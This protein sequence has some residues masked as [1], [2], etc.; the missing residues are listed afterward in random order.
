M[1][2]LARNSW[3]FQTRDKRKVKV[4]NVEFNSLAPDTAEEMIN[5]RQL[6]AIWTARAKQGSKAAKKSKA[7]LAELGRKLLQDG[8][9]AMNGVEVLGEGMEKSSR[10]VVILKPDEGYKAYGEMLHYYAIQNLVEYMEARTETTFESMSKELGGERV[11]DWV[12]FGGQLMP[13]T[14]ADQLRAD[15]GAGKL[16]SWQKIHNRYDEI[17]QQYPLAKQRH[18][19]A[20]LRDVCGGGELDKDKW[21]A[22]LDEAVRIQEYVCEQVYASR[23]K[24]YDNPFRRATY[25]SD[26][27]MIAAIGTIED[28]SFVKQV[29]KE[30]QEFKTRIENIK[31]RP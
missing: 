7:E 12:N 23:K 30:T 28:N 29:W 10:D 19:F 13:A 4:Q 8:S 6:L 5:G 9:K 17:W 15:I 24:D 18:S 14:D 26:E 31:K 3:K 11:R 2:A 22:M 21:S 27:E 16:D 1:Y 20:V 25:R